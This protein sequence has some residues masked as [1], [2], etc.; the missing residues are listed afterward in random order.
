MVLS[1][2]FFFLDHVFGWAPKYNDIMALGN[3]ERS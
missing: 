3:T 2:V 1:T